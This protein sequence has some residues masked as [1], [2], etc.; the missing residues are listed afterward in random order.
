LRNFAR[1][2]LIRTQRSEIV[3]AQLC[4]IVVIMRALLMLTVVDVAGDRQTG[5]H[6]C[7]AEQFG[8]A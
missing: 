1:D 5:V 2:R 4:L 3:Q 8:I 7:F 6:R